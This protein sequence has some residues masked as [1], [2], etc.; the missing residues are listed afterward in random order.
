MFVTVI[1]VFGSGHLIFGSIHGA[2]LAVGFSAAIIFHNLL[3]G[4]VRWR[5]P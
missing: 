1:L 3:E 4:T 5:S 2:E